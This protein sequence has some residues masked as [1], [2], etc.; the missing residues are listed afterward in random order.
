[1]KTFLIKLLQGTWSLLCNLA[2]KPAFWLCVAIV[3]L[4]TIC[5][6]QHRNLVQKE[7]ERVRLEDNQAAALLEVEKYRTEN[8]ELVASVQ[9]L[10]LKSEELGALIPK[11]EKEIKSLK[12]DLRNAKNLA[13]V[14]TET[15]VDVTTPLQSEI[16]PAADE[17][18]KEDE[19]APPREFF[20]EDDWI[21]ISGKVYPD[22][23]ACS[24]VSKDT[25]ALIAYY[26][27]K[28]CLFAKGRKGK[29]IKYD[30]KTKNPHTDIKSVEYIEI[31]E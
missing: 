18:E 31:I 11:Y 10:S 28:R 12:I 15:T 3:A 1:M 7:Q 16:P 17:P 5:T 6:I 30:V 4:M 22:S 13:H 25:L 8:G 14:E 23:V 2:K 9:A 24:F 19:P 29:L 20:W 21:S 27:K 26:Q